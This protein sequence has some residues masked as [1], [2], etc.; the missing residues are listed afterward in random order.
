MR[1]DCNFLVT[2]DLETDLWSHQPLS[3]LSVVFVELTSDTVLFAKHGF[4][5]R[6]QV[7]ALLHGE[8]TDVSKTIHLHF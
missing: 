5:W 2:W 7:Y 6:T 4:G 3:V 1:Q 8:E